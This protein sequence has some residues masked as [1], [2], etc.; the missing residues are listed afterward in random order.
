MAGN[1]LA[2]WERPNEHGELPGDICCRRAGGDRCYDHDR[3]N[4]PEG[5]TAEMEEA[6]RIYFH[7]AGGQESDIGPRDNPGWY[8]RRAAKILADRVKDLEG[9]I[10][11]LESPEFESLVAR[12]EEADLI[13][14][15]MADAE[16]RAASWKSTLE[17]YRGAWVRE[18]GPPYRQ[19]SHDIDALVLT[20]QDRMREIHDLRCERNGYIR[21]AVGRGLI[22]IGKILAASAPRP[23]QLDLT[24]ESTADQD[25]GRHRARRGSPEVW[26]LLDEAM[27]YL[28]AV[29][30]AGL[31]PPDFWLRAE[32]ARK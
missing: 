29:D 24:A 19:K 13:S 16:E 6:R 30:E 10:A 4:Y 23:I 12:L 32:A 7:I 22:E 26:A 31:A 8:W 14:A 20:T 25:N 11:D 1:E 27:E 3:R 21:G 2:P 9:E 18:I 17:M 28:H 15:Q 5:M